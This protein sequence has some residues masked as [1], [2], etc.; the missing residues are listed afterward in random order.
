MQ[1]NSRAYVRFFN[2]ERTRSTS[3]KGHLN[4]TIFPTI[5][6]LTY[7][8][9]ICTWPILTYDF[10]VNVEKFNALFTCLLLVIDID[11]ELPPENVAVFYVFFYLSSVL[12]C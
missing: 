6:T 2:I 10:L 11:A 4:D 9:V 5:V 1:L 7:A 3:S 8:I 12:K